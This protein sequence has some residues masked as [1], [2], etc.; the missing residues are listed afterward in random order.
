MP[1]S[2]SFNIRYLYKSL[3]T[4]IHVPATLQHG[5]KTTLCQ[6]KVDTGSE[7]CLF[8]RDLA[9][10]L[11][12]DVE[13]GFRRELRTLTSGGLIA[14]GHTITLHTLGLAFDSFV[15]FAADYY[16]LRNILGRDGWLQKVR[17]AIV[18]YDLEIYLNPWHQAD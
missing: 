13:S 11:G 5:N 17:L 1:H 9:D 6:A 2:L 3:E 4:G 16:L 15:Y 10:A 7:V 14:Y 18:D 12:I 8:Q